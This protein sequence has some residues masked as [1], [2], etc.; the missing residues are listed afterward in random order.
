MSLAHTQSWRLLS[1][2]VP[3]GQTDGT[4]ASFF[5]G[6]HSAHSGAKTCE[7]THFSPLVESQLP[8]SEGPLQGLTAPGGWPCGQLTRPWKWFTR[9]M[10]VEHWKERD[11]M[12]SSDTL[13]PGN[14]VL[15]SSSGVQGSPTPPLWQAIGTKA[16]V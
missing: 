15:Y 12:F 7:G 6:S 14:C 1:H 9:Q 10:R 16:T 4:Q 13:K 11:S 3:L 2:V 8:W 5:L